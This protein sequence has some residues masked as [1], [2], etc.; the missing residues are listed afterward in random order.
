LYPQRFGK[1]S[2]A[3]LVGA[4][5]RLDRIPRSLRSSGRSSLAGRSSSAAIL[6][7]R[8]AALLCRKL[9]TLV[10]TITFEDSRA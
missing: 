3:P 5:E 2:A 8:C 6:V 10:D 1:K 7:A 9:A 4:Y